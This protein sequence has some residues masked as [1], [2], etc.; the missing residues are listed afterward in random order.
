LR[1]PAEL[2]STQPD[3]AV[4]RRLWSGQINEA[5]IADLKTVYPRNWRQYIEDWLICEQYYFVL[6]WQR[7]FDSAQQ[8]AAI[9]AAR[10]K[11]LG[12]PTW[13]WR[14]RAGDA[15]FHAQSYLEAQ[16][17]YDASLKENATNTSVLLK[18]SDVYFIFGDLEKE[19]TYREKV[20][21]TLRI[22]E[23]ISGPQ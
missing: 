17:L 11:Q 23:T 3:Q 4:L 12:L 15:A 6:L 14:E 21:G 19:Q 20:Y 8:Y 16:H 2:I 13:L 5:V 7:S 22:S 9:L 1:E 10:H 18:L